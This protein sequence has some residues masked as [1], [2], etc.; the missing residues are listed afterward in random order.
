MDLFAKPLKPEQ[1][2]PKI[3]FLDSL[4]T[5][6][7]VEGGRVAHFRVGDSLVSL[8]LNCLD[9]PKEKP[10]AGVGVGIEGL[11][12]LTMQVTKA[13][14]HRQSEGFLISSTTG[15]IEGSKG[16]ANLCDLINPYLILSQLG[17]EN[18]IT[19]DDRNKIFAE[20]IRQSVRRQDERAELVTGAIQK[21]F[22]DEHE[23]VANYLTQYDFQIIPHALSHP[24]YTLVYAEVLTDSNWR[25]ALGKGLNEEIKLFARFDRLIL[26][27]LE[28][29]AD[30]TDVE[31]GTIQACAPDIN[32]AFLA[33]A[34][35]KFNL[36]SVLLDDLD[37]CPNP[38]A[39]YR[40]LLALADVSAYEALQVEFGGEVRMFR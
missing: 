25:D 35:Q 19:I 8:S 28:R 33:F 21:N 34:A 29:F 16:R 11:F 5:T 6:G 15:L 9:L 7:G 12:L 10:S 23:I 39:L 31:R 38:E 32:V 26:E 17:R 37:G 13:E 40:V 2:M 30:L 1:V 36:K 27:K 22:P 4:F 14:D 20:S 24:I 3:R 18:L